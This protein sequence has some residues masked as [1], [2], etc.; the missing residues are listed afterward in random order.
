MPRPNVLFLM[1]DQMQGRLLESTHPARLPHLRALAARGLRFARA[2]TPNPVCSPARASL[3]T[4]LLPHNH[5]V[6]QVNHCDHSYGSNL[7]TDR[8]HWA[9]HLQAAGYQTGYFGKWHVERSN[10]LT[11]FGW[12]VDGNSHSALFRQRAQQLATPPQRLREIVLHGPPGYPPAR[13]A[14]VV[15]NPPETRGLGIAC[16]LASDFLHSATAG[17]QPW[18]CFVSLTEPHDPYDCGA[19]AFAAYDSAAVEPPPNWSDDLAGRPTLYRRAARN[20]AQLTPAQ[21]REAAVCYWALCDEVDEQFGGLLEQV[22]AAGQLDDTLV[23]LTA[24]HGDFLGAH[25]LYQ[26]NVGA[27][28]EAYQVPLLLAGPG[29]AAGAVSDARV[30]LQDLG[31]TVLEAVGLTPEPTADSRSA[32][33]LLAAPSATAGWQ[34]GYAEYSGT[35]H[36]WSQRVLW[37]GPWKFVWNGFDADELYH[38][39]DDPGELHNLAEDHAHDAV[40]RRMMATI[41]RRLEATGDHPL[42]H[43]TYAA[44]RLAA[45]GPGVAA[46]PS[47]AP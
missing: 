29:V 13:L 25:G 31:A 23:V 39:D 1:V 18:C 43:C 24:D 14:S 38:L 27:F 45:Y 8:Q 7:Q 9:Q 10:D 44:L 33:A 20:F 46:D 35:R 4:G 12:S 42:G 22:A 2:Y 26:K 5:G 17:D 36:W 19:A 40:V 16:S 41:Y 21:Q 6:V 3:M 32:A 30:G 11:R 37:D 28:E 34:Q 15:T 47:E